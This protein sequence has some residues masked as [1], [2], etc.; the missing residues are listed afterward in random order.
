MTIQLVER[1]LDWAIALFMYGSG[2]WL[3]YAAIR[4]VVTRPKASDGT[5]VEE[6]PIFEAAT[7]GSISIEVVEGAGFEEEERGAIAETLLE[8]PLS[9]TEPVAESFDSDPSETETSVEM[10]VDKP[11]TLPLLSP[12]IVSAPEISP[13]VCE[14]V[15]WKKWKVGEL[16]QARITSVCGVRTTPIGSKR[17]LKKADLI[18]QYEQNLKRMTYD[19]ETATVQS[20]K[21]A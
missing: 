13:I 6:R 2:A 11:V 16:R 19:G 17:K 1:V 4:F 5:A 21:I 20:E 18:A 3:S 15:N 8:V 14:P 12:S 9:S 7:A 10:S